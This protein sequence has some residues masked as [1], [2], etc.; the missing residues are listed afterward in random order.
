MSPSNA[1]Y[2]FSI[3]RLTFGFLVSLYYCL[4]IEKLYLGGRVIYQ[5]VD[6]ARYTGTP[7][8]RVL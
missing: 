4:S 7:A 5:L 8:T 3:L 1:K 2:S 6:L